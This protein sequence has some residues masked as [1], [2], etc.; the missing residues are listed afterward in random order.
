MNEINNGH[1]DFNLLKVFI[2][3]YEEGS[4]SKAS[5]RLGVTQS[6]VSAALKRLRILYD[7]QLFVRTGNGFK[8]TSRSQVIKPMID[9][10]FGHVANTFLSNS[11]SFDPFANQSLIIGLSDDFELA[12]G[13]RLISLAKSKA[14]KLKLVFRQTNS[15]KVM[16]ALV[17]KQIDLAITSSYT[18]SS[19]ISSDLLAHGNY[20]C[21]VSREFADT[22]LPL[23]LDTYLNAEHVLISGN[24]LT[25]IVDDVLEQQ[26]EKRHVAVA[27]THFSALPFLIIGENS[28]ATLP[29]H[30]A[31]MIG[32]Q[33]G[34]RQSI[35]PIEFEDYPI[36]VSWNK[37]RSKDPLVIEG[38]LWIK[39]IAD[40][41]F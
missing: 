36:S 27:T 17:S 9:E 15:Q 6:A 16:D 19:F 37:T 40:D 20:S 30:A 4:A 7:D 5:V 21:V 22:K 12:L 18:R 3:L 11:T 10:A 39:Q 32:Q 38:I 23:T 29:R 35:C 28:L 25:G 2:A 31:S 26:G 13:S 41:V 14:P 8:P 1:I 34:L 24:G 33:C